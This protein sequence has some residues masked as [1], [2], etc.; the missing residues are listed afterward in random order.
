ML[1]MLTLGLDWC[2]KNTHMSLL[3][4]PVANLQIS[5]PYSRLRLGH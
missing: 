5:K 4:V 2:E 3:P 1:L